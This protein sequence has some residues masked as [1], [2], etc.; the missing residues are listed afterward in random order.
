[1]TLLWKAGFG[2]LGMASVPFLTLER[3]II[4]ALGFLLASQQQMNSTHM[5][6]V[7]T[8]TH[9][10]QILGHWEMYKHNIKAYDKILLGAGADSPQKSRHNEQPDESVLFL[11]TDSKTSEPQQPAFWD[12]PRSLYSK[13]PKLQAPSCLQASFL[14]LSF[15]CSSAN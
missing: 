14:S 8:A 4:I 1:M 10:K 13:S 6:K 2:G 12:C 15:R 3:V 5:D 11:R 9:A 7:T